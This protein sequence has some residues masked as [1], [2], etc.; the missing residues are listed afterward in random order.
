MN[1]VVSGSAV[2]SRIDEILHNRDEKRMD[3]CRNLG[4]KSNTVSAWLARDSVPP[5][6]AMLD[7]SEYLNVSLEWL[8]T[9]KEA[10][11][12]APQYQSFLND[13]MALPEYDFEELQA[14]VKIKKDRLQKVTV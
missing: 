2:V 5:V 6:D 3:M 8:A 9:G 10:E 12:I 7:I 1:V 4:I 13:V 14:I 11:S